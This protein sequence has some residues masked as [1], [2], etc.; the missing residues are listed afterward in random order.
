[1]IQMQLSFN[2]ESRSD[3]DSIRKILDQL[4]NDDKSYSSHISSYSNSNT[5]VVLQDK[6]SEITSLKE[7]NKVQ[8]SQIEE[9]KKR[10]NAL[11][12]DSK[13]IFERIFNDVTFNI[14]PVEIEKEEDMKTIV[15]TKQIVED[16]VA[17][18]YPKK[19]V[20]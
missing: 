7:K 13:G 20:A 18:R 8:E 4:A 16:A 6:E 15:I 17:T 5:D 10:E 12:L 1:M 3:R 14:E 9:L 19:E 2:P 11:T